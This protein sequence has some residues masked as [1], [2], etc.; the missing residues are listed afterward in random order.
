MQSVHTVNSEWVKW[1]GWAVVVLETA[2]VLL[3]NASP[4]HNTRVFHVDKITFV[5]ILLTPQF[6]PMAI[7]F[8][9]CIENIGKSFLHSTLLSA[10]PRS[11]TQS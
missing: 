1:A 11:G 10:Q 6:L 5:V 8:W 3:S 4:I 2:F 7:G 9:L